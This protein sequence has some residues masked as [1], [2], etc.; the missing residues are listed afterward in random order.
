[1]TQEYHALTQESLNFCPFCRV[2]TWALT[3]LRQKNNSLAMTTK[4]YRV[5]F[6]FFAAILTS[7]TVSAAQFRGVVTAIHDGDTL[8]ITLTDGTKSRVRLLGT[9]SPEVWVN[10]ESQ[11]QTAYTAR[12]FLMSLIPIGASV[13]VNTTDDDVTDKHNRLLGQVVYDNTDINKAM[14]LS[15]WSVFYLIA[16]F[17][18]TM[19]KVYSETAKKAFEAGNGLYADKYK[20]EELPYNF[21]LRVMGGYARNLVGDIE[22]KKLYNQD[23]LDQVPVYSRV[24]FPSAAIARARGYNF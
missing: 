15:G 17:D 7:V 14:L 16:P 18:K 10:G 3:I 22:T 4:T 8:N 20:N 2:K 13:T 24:F 1:M 12:D 19:A 6:I 9:D 23:N 5:F 21:R 11:G